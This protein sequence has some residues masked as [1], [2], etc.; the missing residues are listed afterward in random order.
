MVE[1]YAFFF[2]EDITISLIDYAPAVYMLY[3]HFL[4]QHFEIAQNIK[5]TFTLKYDGE[6]VFLLMLN[7]LTG[8]FLMLFY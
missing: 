1:F 3:K 7:E 6:T 5:L 2:Y 4:F 8:I